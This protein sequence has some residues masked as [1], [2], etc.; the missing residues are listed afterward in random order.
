M[1]SQYIRALGVVVGLAA[2][3]GMASISADQPSDE[4]VRRQIERQLSKNEAFRDVTI[5]V[6][7]HVASLHGAVPTLQA[8]EQ[9]IHEARAVQGVREVVSHLLIPSAE[10]DSVLA[11]EVIKAIVRYPYY[12][13]FDYIEGT[14]DSGVVTLTGY[15]LPT[16]D[17]KNAIVR[18]VSR[19]PGVQAIQDEI[20]VLSPSSEDHRLRRAIARRIFRSHHFQRFVTMQTPPF[21]IIVH[22]SV[23][24]LVGVVQSEIDRREMERITRQTQGVLRVESVL[25]TRTGG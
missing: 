9:A 18:R 20:R 17:K 21:H 5:S 22:R 3:L 15:V 4:Q 11:P 24:T 23:V 2:V 13:L 12:T 14:I 16:P 1:R 7:E 19:V 10:N 25:E 6:Q 8:R